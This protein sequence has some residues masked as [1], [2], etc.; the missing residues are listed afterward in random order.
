M[1]TEARTTVPLSRYFI[2]V[3]IGVGGLLWDLYSKHAVFLRLGFPN[4]RARWTE[5]FFGGW[6]Q[7]TLHTHFNEGALWGVGQGLSWLFATLSVL[8]AG[9]VVYWLFVRGA[10]RSWWLTV[11]LA[12]I[13]GGTLGNL[14]DR[15][16][17][18]GYVVNGK[19]I[20]AVRDFL[21]FRLGNY[22]WPI[23]NFADVFLV[24]GAI[25]LVLHSL[26]AE[27]DATAAETAREPLDREQIAARPS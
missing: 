22:D 24:T 12:L 20:F 7:F 25:M 4:G 23:F 11:A 21:Y 18:H 1:R 13:M 19:V 14:Y 9:F 16:G 10:A 3:L 27:H 6:V 2:F 26:V 8:A 5:D 15:L 17:W